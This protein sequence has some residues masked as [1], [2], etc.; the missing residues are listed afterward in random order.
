MRFS[1]KTLYKVIAVR[2]RKNDPVIT[3]RDSGDPAPVATPGVL[4]SP[5]LPSDSSEGHA[6]AAR[7]ERRAQA[8]TVGMSDKVQLTL[9]GAQGIAGPIPLVGSPLKAAIGGLLTILQTIDVGTHLTI[10]RT[11]PN[12]FLISMTF[13]D[14]LRIR[15]P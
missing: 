14:M 12:L 3:C 10:T 9:G 4:F 13:R 7:I 1:F 6:V 5:A 8:F 11:V 15:R 2:L